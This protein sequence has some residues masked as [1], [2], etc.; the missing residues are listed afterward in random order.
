MQGCAG[1]VVGTAVSGQ[2]AGRV[3]A[4]SASGEQRLPWHYTQVCPEWQRERKNQNRQGRRST[5]EEAVSLGLSEVGKM[6]TVIS[7][8][9]FFFFFFQCVASTDPY[10]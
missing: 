10:L 5:S 9:C 1:E 3:S 4:A 2:H 6:G 8:G 7:V